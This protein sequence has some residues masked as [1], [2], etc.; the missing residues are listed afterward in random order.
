MKKLFYFSLILLGVSIFSACRPGEEP[1]QQDDKRVNLPKV[2]DEM[3]GKDRDQAISTMEKY[4]FVPIEEESGESGI[5]FASRKFSETYSALMAADDDAEE[6]R[7][8]NLIQSMSLNMTSFIWY[9]EDKTCSGKM[10]CP[11]DVSTAIVREQEQYLYNNTGWINSWY[12]EFKSQEDL[13]HWEDLEEEDI[14]FF[15]YEEYAYYRE[16]HPEYG[17]R[18]MFIEKINREE[19]AYLSEQGGKKDE[20]FEDYEQWYR[21]EVTPYDY[22]IESGTFT[23]VYARYIN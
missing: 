13:E 7:L 21:Y 22:N 10:S 19:I 4:G 11:S 6:D 8:Y 9:A 2:V 16:K 15:D 5:F 3:V 20:N 18:A 23:I 1:N 12:T 17:D 14:T